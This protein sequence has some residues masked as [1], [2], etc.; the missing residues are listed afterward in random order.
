MSCFFSSAI[1]CLRHANRWYDLILHHI[2]YI[3]YHTSYIIYH[4]SYI[5][6]HISYIIYHNHVVFHYNYISYHI[7]WYYLI[8]F[9]LIWA[10]GLKFY[11]ALSSPQLW[12]LGEGGAK[13]QGHPSLRLEATVVPGDDHRWPGFVGSFLVLSC[14]IYR[15]NPYK[16]YMLGITHTKYTHRKYLDHRIVEGSFFTFMWMDLL[17]F[18]DQNAV[19][20]IATSTGA[21]CLGNQAAT[22]QCGEKNPEQWPFRKA[23][24]LRTESK[25]PRKVYGISACIQLPPK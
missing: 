12:R 6:Y 20:V 1:I 13:H 4:T 23:E 17:R 14:W 22:S 16:R 25:T 2:S 15:Y 10:G 21:H 11:P 7:I 9:D 18:D 3:V 5:I 24:L 19:T 8:W